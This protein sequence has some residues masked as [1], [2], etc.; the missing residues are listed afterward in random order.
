MKCAAILQSS[1]IPWKGY[2]DLI[3]MADE[4]I[5]YDSV[6][7]T[8]GDWRNRNKIKTPNGA[9]WLTIPIRV[10][11]RRHQKI[12]EAEV[13]NRGWPYKHWRAI[14]LNYSRAPYFE[15]FAPTLCD[16]YRRCSDETHLSTINYLF[17][18]AIVDVLGIKTHITW[19]TD[20][21]LVGGRTECLANLCSQAGA[22]EYLS[23]PAA[24]NYL[25]EALFE[26]AGCQ[27]RWMDYG[28]YP[29]YRQLY[30]PPFIHEVT[31]IDLIMNEGPNGAKKYMLSFG[32]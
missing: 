5:L 14:C 22:T 26:A 6:Q 17:I 16:L 30:C 4:F 12:Q 25:Y 20:Y 11:G 24:K 10:K 28:G 31:I 13:A 29:E 21:E 32:E 18:Q 27:V 19:S 9:M 2:F 1:Y 3:N 7:Y 8:R 15:E 23:G